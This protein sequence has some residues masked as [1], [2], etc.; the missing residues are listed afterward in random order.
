M[1]QSINETFHAQGILE[2]DCRTIVLLHVGGGHGYARACPG[3]P[4]INNWA[5]DVIIVAN[6]IFWIR[7][8]N[9][10]YRKPDTISDGS[11]DGTTAHL[12]I[13]RD[14]DLGKIFP[15]DGVCPSTL[16][17][18]MYWFLHLRQYSAILGVR[19][20]CCSA[21]T[22]GK[23]MWNRSWCFTTTTPMNCVNVDTYFIK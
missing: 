7:K 5:R 23:E 22:R 17:A 6:C 14:K 8:S 10:D 12:H 16:L 11:G 9:R 2:G 19:Q 15:G 20:I 4:Q 13:L 21:P 1:Q 18:V 3:W